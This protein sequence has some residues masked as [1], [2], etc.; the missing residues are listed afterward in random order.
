MTDQIP[1]D[2][3]RKIA[4]AM[5]DAM[6]RV[7]D[8]YP[9]GEFLMDMSDYI[10]D[11]DALLPASPRPTLADMTPEER[12]ACQWMQADTK[13][14]GRVVI[15]VP[16]LSDG[17]A[18]LL[19]RCGDVIY[20]RYVNVTPRP[21]LPLLEW[22]GNKDADPAPAPAL[23]E[24]W[25]LADHED[26]GRGVVTNLTPNRD[27]RVYFVI[28]ADDPMGYDWLFCDPDDLT[29]LDQGADTSDTVP[30]STLAVGSE[31]DDAGALRW[32][33]MDSGFARIV[34]LDCDGEPR[35]WDAEAGRWR[36]GGP[37]PGYTPY[38]IV[39]T[40]QEADQ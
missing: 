6:R 19:D 16:D 4:T 12:D 18:A 2:K 34:M 21:D 8:D 31:W 29:Y 27:G 7:E 32:A 25:R 17:R 28:P 1:A 23:P 36:N 22:P 37:M 14:W 15:I 5:R 13:L 40:E 20:G 26:H 35:V 3:V 30:E 9:D 11:I 24:G 38:T 10:R 33:C 39:H